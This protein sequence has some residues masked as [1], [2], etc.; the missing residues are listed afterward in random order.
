MMDGIKRTQGDN[1]I[2]YVAN[3]VVGNTLAWNFMRENWSVLYH[4]YKHSFSAMDRMVKGCTDR[5]NSK[6]E[7]Q[8]VR[9]L[10]FQVFLS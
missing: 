1:V 10:F 6:W 3:N 9:E 8:Q 5:F 2:N 7:L 4:R